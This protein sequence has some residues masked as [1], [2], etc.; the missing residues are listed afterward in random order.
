MFY[1][2]FSEYFS[3]NFQ[4]LECIFNLTLLLLRKAS[5]YFVIIPGTVCF[6]GFEQISFS[7]NGHL[8]VLICPYND[9]LSLETILQNINKYGS[10]FVVYFN[11]FFEELSS[12]KIDCLPKNFKNMKVNCI[13][14]S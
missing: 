10:F 5:K 13:C 7:T 6:C 3:V 14:S 12:D 11:L 1:S 4:G 2:I 9:W 8:K